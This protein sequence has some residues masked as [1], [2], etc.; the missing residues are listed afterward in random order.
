MDIEHLHCLSFYIK[1]SR[2]Y[3]NH[4]DGRLFSSLFWMKKLVNWSLDLHSWFR[5][6]PEERGNLCF[7][8]SS[9][10]FINMLYFVGAHVLS[11]T[12]AKALIFLKY[13]LNYYVKIKIFGQQTQN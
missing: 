6:K 13:F 5:G 4:K 12:E 8:M 2:T 9:L 1:L 11:K 7:P 10:C 3:L